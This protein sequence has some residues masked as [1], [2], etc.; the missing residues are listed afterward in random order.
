MFHTTSLSKDT[1]LG[2]CAWRKWRLSLFFRTPRHLQPSPYRLLQIH[3]CA[4]TELII[5]NLRLKRWE[6][7]TQEKS[8]KMCI[9][10]SEEFFN[11][12]EQRGRH[13]H[14]LDSVFWGHRQLWDDF[15]EVELASDLAVEVMAKCS[16][17]I[18]TAKTSLN[19]MWTRNNKAVALKEAW[20]TMVNSLSSRI[21]PPRFKY[22]F[23]HLLNVWM[24]T[25]YLIST[26]V[27]FLIYEIKITAI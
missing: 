6:D 5:L 4:F 26:Y 14:G 27:S 11:T 18:L 20:Y 12:Q 1:N 7:A 8:K 23:C 13:Q 21:G 10:G 16:D 2:W 19:L 24:I 3:L 17:F 15:G 22:H 9:L 25:C